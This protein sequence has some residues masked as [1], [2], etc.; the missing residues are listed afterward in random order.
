[1]ETVTT[2]TPAGSATPMHGH[3]KIA[4]AIFVGSLVIGCALILCAE[5]M[6]PA[7]YE[8]HSQGDSVTS[9]LIFDRDS[10]RTAPVEIG[11]KTPTQSLRD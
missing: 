2:V 7:Q 10:G 5:L 1:M 8:F 11:S 6:K 9:Y 3:H 4:A